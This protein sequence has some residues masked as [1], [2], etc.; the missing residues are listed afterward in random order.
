LEK[1][2]GSKQQAMKEMTQARIPSLFR[3]VLYGFLPF[4][5]IIVSPHISATVP[6]VRHIAIDGDYSG[7]HENLT[8]N[9]S[10]VCWVNLIQDGNQITGRIDV[11]Y[12]LIGG[13]FSGAISDSKITFRLYNK[14]FNIEVFYEGEIDGDVIRGTYRFDGKDASPAQRGVWQWKK[15]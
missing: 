15:M 2:A 10:A 5:V 13:E 11:E 4:L 14:E 6:H 12:P 9:K 3:C 7:I 1:Q 8:F